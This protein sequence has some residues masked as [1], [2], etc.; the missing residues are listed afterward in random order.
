MARESSAA[1]RISG[2][3]QAADGPD[4]SEASEVAEGEG[5][6][7]DGVVSAAKALR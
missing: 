1:L 3:M 6:G 5:V 4:R 7:G 2:E